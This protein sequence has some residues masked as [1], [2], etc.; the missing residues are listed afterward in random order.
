MHQPTAQSLTGR[1]VKQSISIVHKSSAKK[2][3]SIQIPH[4]CPPLPTD[5]FFFHVRQIKSCSSDSR[6]LGL[7]T[8]ADRT[9]FSEGQRYPFGK[10][11]HLPLLAAPRQHHKKQDEEYL[12][13]QTTFRSKKK[14]KKMHP[15]Q[16]NFLHARSRHAPFPL[17]VRAISESA[18]SPRTR[19]LLGR[20]PT[21]GSSMLSRAK[22]DSLDSL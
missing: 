20:R 3:I 10:L 21:S 18:E 16:R 19:G 12:K 2:H 15:G 5:L 8:E 13:T 9:Y 4:N 22:A 14:K 7:R 17:D 1:W 11:F 6:F